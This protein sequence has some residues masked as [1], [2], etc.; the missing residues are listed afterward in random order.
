MTA[1]TIPTTANI[2][3]AIFW[4]TSRTSLPLCSYRCPQTGLRVETYRERSPFV[5]HQQQPV[6]I[7]V[8]VLDVLLSTTVHWRHH[9]QRLCAR[10]RRRR[11][12]L[13]PACNRWRSKCQRYNR[14]L[15]SNH[16]MA[17]PNCSTAMVLTQINSDKQ[18]LPVVHER[19]RHHA[20][21]VRADRHQRRHLGPH[22]GGGHHARAGCRARR[23]AP[24]T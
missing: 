20:H 23:P 6:E 9:R 8:F 2:S 1:K 15:Y 24:M 3:S 10:R 11:D 22:P 5:C 14:Y 7:Y 13:R 17:C 18:H 4:A 12:R 19:A 21:P 16:L